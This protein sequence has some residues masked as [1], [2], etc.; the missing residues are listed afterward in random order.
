[1]NVFSTEHPM[2][3]QPSCFDAQEYPWASFFCSILVVALLLWPLLAGFVLYSIGNDDAAT[4]EDSPDSVLGFIS[5]VFTLSLLLA[6]GVV[7]A[8]RLLR[9]HFQRKQ[10][11]DVRL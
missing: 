11:A 2:A 4:P 8:Y 5:A 1:M 9:W 6:F 7:S 10:L 3:S